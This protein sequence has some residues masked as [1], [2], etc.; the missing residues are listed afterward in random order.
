MRKVILILFSTLMLMAGQLPKKIVT[1]IYSIERD[2]RVILSGN[3]PRGRSGIVV[4]SYGNGLFAITHTAISLGGN[5]AIIDNY[6]TLKHKDLPTIKTAI[7]K[8]DKVI[9]GNLYNNV[10]LIAPD[11][12]SYGTIT[13]SINRVWI[14]P[15]MYAYYLIKNNESRV[16]LKNLKKFA[17]ENQVGLV[18]IV[19]KDGI[20]VL[21][22]ISGVYL[23]KLPL[24][25]NISKAQ[26]P[27][28][29]RFE[30]IDT[31]I[32][33]QADKKEFPAYYKGVEG[34]R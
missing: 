13:K 25:I 1:T 19:A 31:D 33:S 32:F 29:A 18:V 4:H 8:G 28:Y 17:I 26:S 34:I 2:G 23:R 27:F 7:Q 3:I 6:K 21:D 22:P 9:F 10:L 16:T 20:R 11:E 12:Q 15:D 30:Q 5:R 24:N 14:H